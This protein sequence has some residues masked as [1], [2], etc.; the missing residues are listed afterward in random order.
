M[1]GSECNTQAVQAWHADCKFSRER[2]EASMNETVRD[3]MTEEVA[4][5]DTKTPLV[6]AAHL[7]R[8][9]DIGDVVITED[10]EVCGILTDRDI[11]IRAIAEGRDPE[12]V[13]VGECCSRDLITIQ[14]TAHVDEAVR[15][16]RDNAV[17]RLIVVENDKPIGILSLG[18]LAVERDRKSALGEISAA[19]P[20]Q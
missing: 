8:D 6:Q 2:K 13:S 12:Q 1:R 9:K 16:M 18:D 15:M 19:P 3:L 14:P 7:M 4:T 11:V 20:N 17:R 5:L 10:E